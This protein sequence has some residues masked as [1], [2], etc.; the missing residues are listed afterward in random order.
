M[1]TVSPEVYKTLKLF[2]GTPKRVCDVRDKTDLSREIILNHIR[3]ARIAGINVEHIGPMTCRYFYIA[4][5]D[6]TNIRKTVASEVRELLLNT[7]EEDAFAI[8]ELVALFETTPTHIWSILSVWRKK[9]AK[10]FS[11]RVEGSKKRMYWAMP[12]SVE[13]GS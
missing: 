8:E 6:C 9:G 4:Q 11:K 2:T 1:G 5:L 3:S 12:E 13:R 10:L 7:P